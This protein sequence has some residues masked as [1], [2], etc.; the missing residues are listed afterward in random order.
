MVQVVSE[1][2]ISPKVLNWLGRLSP[3]T[4]RVNTTIFKNFMRW[5]REN[6]GEFKDFTGDD[7]IKYQEEATNSHRY[8]L[9]DLMQK[10]LSSLTSR[11]GYKR[12]I[13]STIKSFFM[14]NRA[15]LPED[16]SFIIRGDVESVRG[17]LTID[18]VRKMILT[19]NEVYQAVFLSMFQGGM[20]LGEM[21]Y[22]NLHGWPQLYEDLKGD[23]EVI[24]VDLPG[25]KMRKNTE[26][27]YTFI[28]SDAIRAIRNYVENVRPENAEA[29]F[30]NK[31]GDPINRDA[32]ALYWRRQT[33]KIGIVQQK[34]NGSKANRYG[35][36]PH[37]MRDLFR[38]HWHKSGRSPEVAEFMMGH[39][40]D[41]N[42]YNKFSNDVDYVRG[43]YIEALELIQIMSSPRPFKLIG[44]S[45]LEKLRR[46]N[47]DLKEQLD[48]QLGSMERDRVADLEMFR[49][50]QRQMEEMKKQIEEMK[51]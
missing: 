34:K 14:H 41:R 44:E 28:G 43:E 4:A 8:H 5:V 49:Q 10:Y 36:N 20:G 17:T 22:W 27:F 32:A 39:T 11:A 33:R 50:M 45:E 24:K 2:F 26:S 21:E 13:R 7:F 48:N 18:E 30:I 1:N 38:T 31:Y 42:N 29:I 25:R 9:V 6:G 46:E 12:K 47:R 3:S 19:C 23:P 51:N 16:P 37:E 40:I 15:E 35:K